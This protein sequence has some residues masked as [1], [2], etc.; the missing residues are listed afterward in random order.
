MES[1]CHFDRRQNKM[2]GIWK[3]S[4]VSG[5]VTIALNDLRV[6]KKKI[7]SQKTQNLF[8]LI[9]FGMKWQFSSIFWLLVRRPV[10]PREDTKT[11]C[12]RF[13]ISTRTWTPRIAWLSPFLWGK[14]DTLNE[15]YCCKWARLSTIQTELCLSVIFILL[16]YC[17]TNR[18][19]TQS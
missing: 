2:K 8:S 5:W 4:V 12:L 3:L 17:F 10:E 16:C 13:W 9:I 1:C 18:W 11:R 6:Q 19:R 15:E 14:W 7:F